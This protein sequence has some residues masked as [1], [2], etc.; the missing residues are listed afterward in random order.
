M[1]EPV[2]LPRPERDEARNSR[3][4]SGWF[5]LGLGWPLLFAAFMIFS[6][7]KTS[8]SFYVEALSHTPG[9][10]WVSYGIL[11]AGLLLVGVGLIVLRVGRR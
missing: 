4:A 1:T 9:G 10:V 2:R 5:L 11:A 3:L 6:P 8:P 7:H